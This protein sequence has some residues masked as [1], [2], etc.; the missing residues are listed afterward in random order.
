V[1]ATFH[2]IDVDIN[3]EMIRL[4]EDQDESRDG[5]SDNDIDLFN[6]L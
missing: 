2:S 1:T 6:D 5:D 3:D 4:E